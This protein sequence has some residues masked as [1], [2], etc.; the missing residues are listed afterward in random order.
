MHSRDAA[1]QPAEA[2][3]RDERS[4]LSHLETV[5]S[6]QPLACPLRLEVELKLTAGIV[7]SVGP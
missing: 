3:V 5:G 1:L 6:G 7:A 4:Y 2:A